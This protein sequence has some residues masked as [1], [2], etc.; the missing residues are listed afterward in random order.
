MIE[1]LNL[2]FEKFYSIGRQLRRIER[3]LIAKDMFQRNVPAFAFVF[4]CGDSPPEKSLGRDRL[5]D[6]GSTASIHQPALTAD[7]E[8]FQVT[9]LKLR[10]RTH[11]AVELMNSHV[12]RAPDGTLKARPQ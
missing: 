2:R 7:A 11:L 6:T 4:K 3:K 8:K 10:I 1:R 9:R 12:R 5:Y